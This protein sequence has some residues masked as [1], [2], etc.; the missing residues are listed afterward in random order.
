MHDRSIEKLDSLKVVK[1]TRLSL[2][3]NLRQPVTC[4]FPNW[5]LGTS[6]WFNRYTTRCSTR[7]GFLLGMESFS[8]IK[9]LMLNPR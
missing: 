4:Q 1:L 8:I 3:E 9:N 5:L 7:Y 2:E 6:I